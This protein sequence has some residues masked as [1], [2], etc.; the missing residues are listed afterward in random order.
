MDKT[1]KKKNAGKLTREEIE[2][3]IK[4]LEKEMRQAAKDLDFEKAAE[5]RDAIIEM[6]AQL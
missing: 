6:K 1:S 4:S 2:K 3:E 5:I